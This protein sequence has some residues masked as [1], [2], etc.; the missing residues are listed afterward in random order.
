[1][2]GGNDVTV[3]AVK[4]WEDDRSANFDIGSE[5]VAPGPEKGEQ[6]AV[7]EFKFDYDFEIPGGW[8]QFLD[9]ES[10]TGGMRFDSAWYNLQSDKG[11]VF[12]RARPGIAYTKSDAAVGAIADHIDEARSNPGASLPAES[13]KVLHGAT[14]GDPLHRLAGAKGEAQRAR[15]NDNR[16]IST[17]FCRTV[18]M[19]PK[20][21]TGGPY[22]CDEYAFASTYEG[23]AR[24][25]YDGA[26][27]ERDYSVRWVNSTVNQEAGRRLGRWHENDRIL[28]RE[29][30]FVPIRS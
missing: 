11:S 27:H 24:F 12:D 2:P 4:E 18:A 8:F 20:P 5:G 19:P 30:F 14:A 9:P 22:D 1:M 21:P 25:L 13:D 26:Q 3:R 7:G 10:P 28:D 16:R 29:A 17:N 6:V 23:A 15:A